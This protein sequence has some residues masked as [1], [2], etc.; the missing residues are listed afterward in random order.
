MGAATASAARI[1]Y[2]ISLKSVADTTIVVHSD[3]IIRARGA[4]P[5]PLEVVWC[6]LGCRQLQSTA[7]Q[8]TT[9]NV[10]QAQL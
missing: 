4:W 2:R 3:T 1:W 5:G 9:D 10:R 6:D 7:E 8:S